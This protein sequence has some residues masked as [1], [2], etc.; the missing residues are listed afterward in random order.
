MTDTTTSNNSKPP[1]SGTNNDALLRLKDQLLEERDNDV[2]RLQEQLE[3]DSRELNNRLTV[4][5][6]ENGTLRAKIAEL[7]MTIA[8]MTIDIHQISMASPSLPIDHDKVC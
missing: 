8:T 3:S 6:N 7:E 4:V 2:K 5:T 1:V